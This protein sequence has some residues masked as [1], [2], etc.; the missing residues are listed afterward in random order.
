M[1]F[2]TRLKN[3]LRKEYRRHYGEDS[4]L[5]KAIGII[6]VG[7]NI[8]QERDDYQAFNLPVIWLEPIPEVFDE[9]SRNMA[10]HPL[11]HAY[12]Y[13]ISD[14]DGEVVDFH[15]SNNEALSSSMLPLKEHQT[16]WPSVAFTQKIALTTFT[17]PTMLQREKIDV[18]LYDTLVMD[19]Q[20]SEMKVM[21]GAL[22]LLPRFKFIKLEV[23]DFEIYEG[24][25][26]KAEVDAFLSEQGYRTKSVLQHCL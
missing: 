10:Y 11:Q 9:L 12:P 20:G 16:L 3:K 26:T 24:C 19:V 13:L 1:N 18:S 14:Q 2:F 21:Q 17:L 8:G 6:H 22:S 5:T 15:I 7:A 23:A 25:T 4:F